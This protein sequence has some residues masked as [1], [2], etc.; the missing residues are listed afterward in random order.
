MLQ[1][2]LFLASEKMT[3]LIIWCTASSCR[4]RP[5]ARRN[6]GSFFF[7][8]AKNSCASVATIL[9]LDFSPQL[10]MKNSPFHVELWQMFHNAPTGL[11]LDVVRFDQDLQKVHGVHGLIYENRLGGAVRAEDLD[12][13]L[14]D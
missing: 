3:L 13:D 11:Q 10:K 8:L 14:F 1:L 9:C 2:L 12:K 6:K 7:E 5:H 4:V